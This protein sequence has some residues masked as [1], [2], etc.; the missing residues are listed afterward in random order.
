MFLLSSLTVSRVVISQQVTILKNMIR[1]LKSSN[2]YRIIRSCDNLVVLSRGIGISPETLCG[3]QGVHFPRLDLTWSV[4]LPPFTLSTQP[5]PGEHDRRLRRLHPTLTEIDRSFED[6]RSFLPSD[7]IGELRFLTHRLTEL[8]KKNF[9]IDF[10]S[11][12]IRFWLENFFGNGRSFLP[13]DPIGKLQSPA[14]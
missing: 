9:I 7:L 3:L 8:S 1:S 4:F 13:S 6:S 10:R 12:S 11:K 14:D 5:A 2:S